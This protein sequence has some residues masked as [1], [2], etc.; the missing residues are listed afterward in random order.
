MATAIAVE[1]L[2]KRYRIGELQASYGTLRESIV[3]GSKRLLGREHAAK[4]REIWA[5]ATCPSMSPRVRCS[6]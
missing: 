5:C 2:S 4:E 1:E 3:R 6:A